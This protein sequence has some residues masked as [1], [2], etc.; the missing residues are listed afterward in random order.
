MYR[1][2]I[3]ISNSLALGCSHTWGIGVEATETWPYLLAAKNFGVPGISSDFIAR[4]APALIAQHRPSIVY[5]LWPD[6]SRFEYWDKNIYRQSLLTD[7]NRIKFMEI[8]T[9]AWLQENFIT[10]RTSVKNLCSKHNIKLVEMTLYDL[11]PYIDHA[12]QWPLSKLG[13]HYSPL[14]HTWVADIF[15]NKQNEQA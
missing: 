6:W 5:V 14:W 13:H 4:T 7:L 12:D 3:E 1:N 8:A 15:R 10:Q 11:I 2:I 9:D